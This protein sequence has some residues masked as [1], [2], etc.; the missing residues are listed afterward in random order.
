[1]TFSISVSSSAGC[2]FDLKGVNTLHAQRG[3]DLAAS[4]ACRVVDDGHQDRRQ[5]NW[6]KK[7]EF[8]SRSL[9]QQESRG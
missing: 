3:S 8:F 5:D 1:M 4:A 9:E 7:S 2:E 6:K